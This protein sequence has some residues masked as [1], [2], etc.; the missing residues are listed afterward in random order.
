MAPGA[1][2]VISIGGGIAGGERGRLMSMIE[3][4]DTD[5]VRLCLSLGRWGGHSRQW[6]QNTSG[7]RAG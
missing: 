1:V 5:R 2:T 6:Y 7:V 3:V 4:P